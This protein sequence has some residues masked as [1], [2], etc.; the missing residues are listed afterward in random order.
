MS[1]AIQPAGKHLVTVGEQLLLALTATVANH[2]VSLLLYQCERA[3]FLYEGFKFKN[4]CKCAKIT[5]LFIYIVKSISDTSLLSS[6]HAAIA[7]FDKRGH[8]LSPYTPPPVRSQG[9]WISQRA[10][11]RSNTIPTTGLK[12]LPPGNV[13]SITM[14]ETRLVALSLPHGPPHAPRGH[15]GRV[16]TVT[17]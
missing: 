14:T 8:F 13:F 17:A 16:L 2:S 1:P 5:T 12:R 9:G 6:K 10:A 7:F 11:R 3:H 4:N 15:S